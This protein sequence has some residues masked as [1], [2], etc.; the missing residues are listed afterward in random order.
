MVTIEFSQDAAQPS[1]RGER[2][3]QSGLVCLQRPD[4]SGYSPGYR[5]CPQRWHRDPGWLDE[6]P[7]VSDA[8]F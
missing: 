3:S 1:P 5:E 7:T 2:V 6:T 8:N 4:G